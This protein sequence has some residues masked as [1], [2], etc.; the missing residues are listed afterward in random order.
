MEDFFKDEV[1]TAYPGIWQKFEQGL[2]PTAEYL[3]PRLFQF[4]TN[5]W[6]VEEAVEQ[7]AVL[8]KTAEQWAVML[9]EEQVEATAPSEA[10]RQN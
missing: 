10:P 9:A 7:A 4:K 1:E 2:C 6:D 3:Q 8:R 5:Y